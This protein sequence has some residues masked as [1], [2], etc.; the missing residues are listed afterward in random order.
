MAFAL[1]FLSSRALIEPIYMPPWPSACRRSSGWARRRRGPPSLALPGDALLRPFGGFSFVSSGQHLPS[2]YSP[3]ELRH[4][5]SEVPPQSVS[6]V[7]T[8]RLLPCRANQRRAFLPGSRP[9]WEGAL[10]VAL[11]LHLSPS[12]LMHE[13]EHVPKIT[14]LDAVLILASFVALALCAWALFDLLPS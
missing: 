14:P 10:L 2:G 12:E 9:H 8:R 4:L 11:R 1:A 7:T 5:K 6:H 13:P 3:L